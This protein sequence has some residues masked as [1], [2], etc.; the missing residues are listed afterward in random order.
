MCTRLSRKRIKPMEN[1]GSLT[2]QAKLKAL[3]TGS[4]AGLVLVTWAVVFYFFED[5]LSP[6]VFRTLLC[7]VS[8]L[9]V[10]IPSWRIGQLARKGYLQK[11]NKNAQRVA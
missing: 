8:I 5:K 2:P 1:K 9:I 4:I 7:S 6:I 11:K 3:R 10:A